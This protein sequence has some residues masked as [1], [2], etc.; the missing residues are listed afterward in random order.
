M[1]P[2]LLIEMVKFQDSEKCDFGRGERDVDESRWVLMV[3]V[4]S[5]AVAGASR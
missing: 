2:S 3:E 4:V 5:V 1:I